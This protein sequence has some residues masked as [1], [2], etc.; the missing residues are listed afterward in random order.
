MIIPPID[1]R[2]TN[3]SVAQSTSRGESSEPV[4]DNDHKRQCHLRLV[5][6]CQIDGFPSVL[7]VIGFEDIVRFDEFLYPAS[8]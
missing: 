4:T 1:Q 5:R 8:R 3:W 6:L 2:H 7:K